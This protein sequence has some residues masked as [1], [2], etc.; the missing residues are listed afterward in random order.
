MRTASP[1]FKWLWISS[2]IVLIVSLIGFFVYYNFNQLLSTALHRSFESN[3]ISDVYE[4]KFEKLRVNLLD[5]DINVINVVMQPRETPLADYPY[6]N[7]T[8]VLKTEQL[9]LINVKLMELLKFD[10]LN[11]D[12]IAI[13]RGEIALTIGGKLP[14]LFPYI[15]STKVNLQDTAAQKR[16]ITSFFLKKFQIV[17]AGIKVNNTFLKQQ[18]SIKSLNISLDNLALSQKLDKDQI[19]CKDFEVLIGSFDGKFQESG[20]LSMSFK[21][22]KLQLDSLR[23]QKKIDTLNYHFADFNLALRELEIQTADSVYHIGLEVFDLSYR[24]KSVQMRNAFFK[25]NLEEKELQKRDPY[26]ITRFTV[27]V[28]TINLLNVDFNSLIYEQNIVIGELMIDKLAASLFKDKT[29]PMDPQRYPGY[30]PQQLQKIPV[31]FRVNKLNATNVTIKNRE[32]LPEGNYA[33]V[34]VNRMSLDATTLTNMSDSSQL[35]V[36]AEAFVQDK[37]NFRVNVAF[38]YLKPAFRVQGSISRFNMAEL[39][40][41]IQSYTPAKINTGKVDGITFNAKVYKT[42]ASGALTFLYH[43]LNIDLQLEERAKWKNTLGAFA[44]NTYLRTSNPLSEGQ[45]PRSV[46]FTVDRDMQKGF[47]NVILK[48]VLTGIKETM[49]PSRENRKAFQ[50]TKKEWKQKQREKD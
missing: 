23:F 21:D 50:E 9:Q 22:Y 47:I 34:T 43:D 16:I 44:A 32:R 6:I 31:P 28:E 26:Q 13:L 3:V 12:R 48:S 15:D 41:L 30:P 46:Q 11:L 25:P 18:F 35:I 38:D 36:N 17:D 5:G 20:L 45:P 8:L 1:G 49:L 10:R 37:A 4:L 27:E 33:S 39:N 24:N 29:K 40:S 2:I 14:L 19:S 42:G 7:S